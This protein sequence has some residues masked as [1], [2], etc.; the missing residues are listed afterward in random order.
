MDIIKSVIFG[1]SGMVG[2][3]VLLECLKSQAV[4]SVLVIGRSS[5]NVEH[6]KLKEIIHHDFTDYSDIK[7]DMKGYNACFFCLGI[8]SFMMKEEDY[9]RITYDYTLEAAGALHELN[10]DMVFCYISGA[11][12]DSSGKGRSMWARIKRKT[13]NDLLKIPFRKVYLFRPGYIQ[14]QRGIRPK[15]TLYRIFY[16]FFGIFYPLLQLLLTDYVTKTCK[17]GL[18]MLYVTVKSPEKQTLTTKDIN[19]FAASYS[20]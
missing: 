11:G 14:P 5:C 17:L 2:K 16:T 1:A 9:K 3:G 18:S 20:A 12:T 19:D 4:K 8:S 6:A 7:E 13:E 10:R 15:T